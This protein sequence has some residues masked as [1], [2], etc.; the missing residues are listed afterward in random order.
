MFWLY[1]NYRGA[2]CLDAFS[3]AGTSEGSTKGVQVIFS[4]MILWARRTMCRQVLF[5]CWALYCY[6]YGLHDV[7]YLI[8]LSSWGKK[9]HKK[10]KKYSRLQSS[11][12]FVL[13]LLTWTSPSGLIL[14]ASTS[15]IAVLITMSFEQSMLF[16]SQKIA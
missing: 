7:V 6:C 2:D 12:F 3:S 16:T 9:F 8:I 11:W 15:W 14:N 10:L 1:H 5:H 4:K 13:K